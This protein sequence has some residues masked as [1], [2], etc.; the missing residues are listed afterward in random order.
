MWAVQLHQTM[1]T[2]FEVEAGVR[3]E[4]HQHAGEQITTVVDGE[5]FFEIPQGVFR[6]GPGDV[7]AIPPNVPHAVFTTTQCA[8]AFDSW[9]PPFPR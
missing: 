6:V 9:S 2:Y 7:I 3:F 4:T 5:L 1:M 8:R